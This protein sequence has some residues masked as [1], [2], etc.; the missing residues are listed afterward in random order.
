MG[1]VGK[2]SPGVPPKAAAG[3]AIAA[4]AAAA[5][6][7]AVAELDGAAI[8]PPPTSELTPVHLTSWRREVVWLRE[9]KRTAEARLGAAQEEPHPLELPGGP[10]VVKGTHLPPTT[11]S[12]ASA[13]PPPGASAAGSDVRSPP[14]DDAGVPSVDLTE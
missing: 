3:V 12:Q 9:W 7:A 2:A 4:A 14:A 6:A 11:C 8:P 5:A 1:L 13:G 10:V